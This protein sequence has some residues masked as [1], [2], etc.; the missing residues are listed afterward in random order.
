MALVCFYPLDLME[1]NGLKNVLTFIELHPCNL[2][3]Y[4]YIY[5]YIKD[6]CLRCIINELNVFVFVCLEN[7]FGRILYIFLKNNFNRY[8]I[9]W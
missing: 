8:Q 5:I 7:N 9:G 3:P 6:H 4:I 1:I 2:N